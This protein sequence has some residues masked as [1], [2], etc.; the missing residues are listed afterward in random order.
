[1]F[2]ALQVSRAEASV[3]SYG[4]VFVIDGARGDAMWDY[5]RNGYQGREI[6]PNIKKYFIDQGVWVKKATSVFPTITGAAMPALLTGCTSE[7]HALPSLYFFDRKTKKYPVLYVLA[8]AFDF[9]SWLSPKVKTIWE[10]F[11]GPNDAISFGPAIH[12]GT[13]DRSFR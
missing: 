13:R 12:R 2:L 9:D 4:L 5:A 10:Y 3:E 7:R 8:E 6:M 1:L 11:E